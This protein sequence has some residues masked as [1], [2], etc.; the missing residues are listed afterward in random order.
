M[1]IRHRSEAIELA[2]IY[3]FNPI[4][5]GGVLSGLD[6]Y[7]MFSHWPFFE[8][9]RNQI[10]LL[11]L[12]ELIKKMLFFLGKSSADDENHLHFWRSI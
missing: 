12:I 2:N 8:F 11:I 7:P 9:R 4:S 10:P 6:E 5:D 3:T 1:D